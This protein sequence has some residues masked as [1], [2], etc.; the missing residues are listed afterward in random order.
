MIEEGGKRAR[1]GKTKQWR[2]QESESGREKRRLDRIHTCTD[3][4]PAHRF[5]GQEG[6]GCTVEEPSVMDAQRQLM[7]VRIC[8][9]S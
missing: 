5:R 4:G 3:S 2:E 9:D 8:E 7:R 1:D 6:S